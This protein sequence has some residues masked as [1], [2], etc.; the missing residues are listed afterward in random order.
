MAAPE[1]VPEM[2][3]IIGGNRIAGF[4]HKFPFRLFQNVGCKLRCVYQ[5]YVSRGT[6][7]KMNIIEWY[8]RDP[9]HPSLSMSML[10]SS[11]QGFW[12]ETDSIRE[13][14]STSTFSRTGPAGIRPRTNKTRT[15]RK[16]T[17]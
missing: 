11:E 1:E 17:D 12:S 7:L 4:V 13:T 16:E 6:E 15:T 8:V 9:I 5:D 3:A 10:T 2:A 14:P